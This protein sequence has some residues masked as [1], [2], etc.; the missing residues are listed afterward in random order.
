MP[1]GFGRGFGA[2]G[3]YGRGGYSLWGRGFGRRFPYF[4]MWG[5]MPCAPTM[6]YLGYGYPYY[7]MAYMLPY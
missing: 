2:W 6:P 1:R 4:P 7:G 3:S 5:A